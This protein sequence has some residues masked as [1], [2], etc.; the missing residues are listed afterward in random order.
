MRI[1]AGWYQQPQAADP[2]H[3]DRY[4]RTMT[5]T[6]SGRP[7]VI[8]HRGASA[9]APE[10]TVEAF[11]MAEAV[12]A[13]GV[14]LDVR[15]TSDD[16][17]VVHHDA[18]V[19]GFGPIWN[20]TFEQL[21]DAHPT[22]PTLD[23]AFA[24]CGRM[25]VNIEIKNHPSEGGF[26]PEHRVSDLVAGWVVGHDVAE[27][28]IVSSFT[29]DTV[30]AVK[31]AAADIITGQL[32]ARGSLIDEW[33]ELATDDG[34]EW[35]LPHSRHLKRGPEVVEAAHDAGLSVGTWTVDSRRWLEAVRREGV[36]AVV[37]N[38]PAKALEVYSD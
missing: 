38:D 36:D 10:N 26:D 9:T 21:R 32:V 14:E 7:L 13:D 11:R 15:T 34:H 5:S 30:G 17:L 3:G 33:I 18:R 31:A 28:V 1:G 2:G 6:P 25:L 12:G 37:T 16:V 20:H 23:E 27:R 24:A 22:I 35:I 4:R 19:S 29:R 8:G